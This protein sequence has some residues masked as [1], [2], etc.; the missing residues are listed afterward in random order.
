MAKVNNGGSYRRAGTCP[1]AQRKRMSNGRGLR[2]CCF[3]NGCPGQVVSRVGGPGGCRKHAWCAMT[4]QYSTMTIA[5]ALHTQTLS[6][7]QAAVDNGEPTS[8][9]QRMSNVQRLVSAHCI[10]SATAIFTCT[11]L[12]AIVFSM[13]LL[14]SQS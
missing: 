13:L 2:Q 10:L 12:L 11:T 4:A 8:T 6:L 7:R 9:T 1:E 3:G 5:C 14:G